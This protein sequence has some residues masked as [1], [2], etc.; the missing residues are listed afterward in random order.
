MRFEKQGNGFN[1][2]ISQ[3]KFN[4]ELVRNTKLLSYAGL[5][6]FPLV[7]MMWFWIDFNNLRLISYIFYVS[8]AIF[9][10]LFIYRDAL[11]TTYCILIYIIIFFIEC[12]ITPYLL[13]S[14]FIPE[15]FIFQKYWLLFSLGYFSIILRH[16]FFVKPRVLN[17]KLHHIQKY[18][19]KGIVYIPPMSK[20]EKF[21]YY[22]LKMRRK[23]FQI[24]FDMIAIAII[25]FVMIKGGAEV[26]GKV[27]VLNLKIYIFSCFSTLLAII[28]S[29]YFAIAFYRIIF[30]IMEEK[31]K[32]TRF[33][34]A[35][36][37]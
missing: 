15:I 4:S 2:I 13:F 36:D 6:V 24:G 5:I 3:L 23:Y 31:A 34:F 8:V 7:I 35:S 16:I 17:K 11:L 25:F 28:F 32:N 21:T 14:K 18:L 22:D 20:L 30:F 1:M 9:L 19:Q 10:L 27:S 33:V 26:Y 37:V 29:G 12:L